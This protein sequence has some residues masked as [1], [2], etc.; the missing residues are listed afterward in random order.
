MP[1]ADRARPTVF[2]RRRPAA[3]IVDAALVDA[4]DGCFWTEDAVGSAY[5]SLRGETRADLAV[6]GG[7]Y[8]GLW[9]A[10]RAKQRDPGRRV[11]LLEGKRLGW[12]ASGRNGG[13][14]DASITHGEENGRSRWETEYDV[15]ERL[16]RENLAGI[17]ATVAEH[18]MDVDLEQTGEL[19]VAVEPHQVAW[20][21]ETAAAGGGTFLDE[22]AVRA[23]V[24]SPTYL[25]GL[26]S[27][28]CALLH[29]AKM[30]HELARV[31]TELGVE[32][33]EDSAV[34]GLSARARR[35]TGDRLHRGRARGRGPGG[36]GHERL[37]RAGAPVPRLHRAGVGLRGDD[38]A[39]DC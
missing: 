33:H 11:V 5:P 29:P 39:S 3:P 13:F 9:T 23:E 28:D 17:V 36:A 14:C 26:F 30:V 6:V 32:I 7:G 35:R 4:A 34:S 38:R 31:A 16:G 37:P 12:A 19:A 27:P 18:A 10:V 2:E 8:T 24:A 22:A 15:L 20:L 21:Q 25:A 1:R